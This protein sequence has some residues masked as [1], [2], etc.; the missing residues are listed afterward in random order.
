MTD[1]YITLDDA[2]KVEG[3]SYE[4][5]KKK[6]QR[7]PEAFKI[8]T[9]AGET[10]GKERVLVALSSLSQ[11]AIK[12]YQRK[13]ELDVQRAIEGVESEDGDEAW[14]VGLELSSYMQRYSSKFYKA[15]EL[16]K[17]VDE[18]LKY[19]GDGKTE[20]IKEYAD[21]IGMSDRN[22]RRKIDKYLEGAAWAIDMSEQDGK[23]YDFYKIL[24]LCPPPREKKFTALTEEMKAAIENIWFD[25]KF[26]ANH[27]KQTKL[28]AILCRLGDQKEWVFIPSYQTVNRYINELKDRYSSEHF[29]VA[30]GEREWK[31]SKMIKRRRNT[32]LLQ[33]MELIMGDGHTFDCWVKVTRGNGKVTAIRPV[34]VA[35]VDVRSRCLVGWAICE[36]PDSQV[37]KQTF[38]HMMYPKKNNPIEGVPRVLLIDNGKDWTAQTLTGRPRKIRVTLDSEIKGFYK[39]VGIEDDMRSLPY[40]AWTKAQVERFFGTVCED[41][42]SEFDSYTG[43][44]TGSRTIGKIKKDIKGMLERDELLSIEEFAAKFDRWVNETYHARVHKGLKKQKEKSPKPIDVFTQAERYYKPAPP[45]DFAQMLLMKCEERTVCGVGF[46]MGSRD[47]QHEALAPYLDKKVDVRYNPADPDTVYVYNKDGKKVCEITSFDGLHPLAERNDERLVSHIQDQNRQK[48]ET[49]ENVKYLQTPYEERI[50]QTTTKNERKV[51]GPALS[52]EARQIVAIPE[53]KQYREEVKARKAKKQDDGKINEFYEKQAEKAMALL[54]KL[55]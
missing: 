50:T 14:Y 12:A 9:E 51:L 32:G 28:Y 23:N 40:Q 52:N 13:Q 26:A 43:T 41:F 16:A 3:I 10:G 18:F 33:V 19:D 24:A 20:Y 11:K 8:K 54:Q 25:K 36:V 49:K 4:A 22:F 15:V 5:M 34:L 48:R 35:L 46:S 47:F 7:N 27:R 55:G 39:S 2:A 6:I 1:K 21:R 30:Q 38:L 42:A 44:L 31:R 53:D 17:Q 29:L 37:I 45:L